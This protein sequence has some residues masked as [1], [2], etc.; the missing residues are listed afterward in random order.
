VHQNVMYSRVRKWEK[1]GAS[2]VK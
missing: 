2:A 1:V